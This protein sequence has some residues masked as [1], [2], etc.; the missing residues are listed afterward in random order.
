MDTG[1]DEKVYSDQRPT[2]L[3]FAALLIMGRWRWG[4]DPKHIKKHRIDYAV[5]QQLHMNSHSDIL[6]HTHSHGHEQNTLNDII[7]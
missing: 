2:K 3:I 4:I 5:L 6:S 1:G 7:M